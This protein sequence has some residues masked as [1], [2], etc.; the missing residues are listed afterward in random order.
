MADMI[1]EKKGNE[2]DIDTSTT[3]HSATTNSTR[4]TNWTRELNKSELTTYQ[5]SIHKV[6]KNIKLK[7]LKKSINLLPVKLKTERNSKYIITFK[8]FHFF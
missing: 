3:K 5:K 8:F 4:Q 7:N 1:R 2:Y 6:Y